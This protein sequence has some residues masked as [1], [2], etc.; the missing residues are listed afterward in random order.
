M[1]NV[2]IMLDHFEKRAKLRQGGGT[3]SSVSSVSSPVKGVGSLSSVVQGAKSESTEEPAGIPAATSNPPLP[4]LDTM[5]IE[6]YNQINLKIIH[7]ISCKFSCRHTTNYSA[8]LP[9]HTKVASDLMLL[10]QSTDCK[11]WQLM[12]SIMNPNAAVKQILRDNV[13][14]F[15]IVLISRWNCSRN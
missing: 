15:Y 14:G 2:A 11:Y 5:T 9:D 10:S 1:K 3:L 7:H 8:R 6:A 12:R 4:P 13:N